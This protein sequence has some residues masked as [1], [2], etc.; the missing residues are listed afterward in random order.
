MQLLFS[1]LLSLTRVV[2]KIACYY[3]YQ[4]ENLFRVDKKMS[5]S[6]LMFFLLNFSIVLLKVFCVINDISV[7]RLIRDEILYTEI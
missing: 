5:K 3:L 2:S 7:L 1:C 4:G 6:S